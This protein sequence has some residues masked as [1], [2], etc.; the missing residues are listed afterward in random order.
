MAKILAADKFISPT[1]L[2]PTNVHIHLIG[3]PPFWLYRTPSFDN[4][5]DY[6]LVDQEKALEEIKLYLSSGGC[7]A[8]DA[9]ARDYGRNAKAIEYIIKNVPKI[10][11]ILVTGFNRGIYLEKWYYEANEKQI[12]DMFLKEIE[13]GIDDTNLRAGAIKV[14]ADYM[15]ILPI[16]LKLMKIATEVYKSTGVPIVI[17]T[18]LGTMALEILGFLEKNGVDPQHMIFYHAD[19]NLDS[20]YWT[21]IAERGAFITIDQIGKIKY[22]PESR[23]IDFIIEMVKRG[24]EDQILLGTD[25]ARRSDFISYGGGPGLEYLFTKFIPFMEMIF[26]KQGIEKKIIQKFTQNNPSKA[27]TLKF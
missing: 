9:T 10:N 21:Q 27:L 3:A 23:R 15:R 18:T 20:W 4:D 14:G 2:G 19:R 16:E 8:L 12:Y 6:S 5:I 1:D 7:S 22:A 26:E 13:T 24:F 17:H 11:L 25:F